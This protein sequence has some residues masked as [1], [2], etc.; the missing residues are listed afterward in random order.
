[1]GYGKAS[2]VY[3]GRGSRDHR[4]EDAEGQTSANANP[5]SRDISAL[6]ENERQ[7]HGLPAIAAM[8]INRD[9]IV[10]Q[11]VVGV[12]KLG[13]PE[14]AHIDDRWHTSHTEPIPARVAEQL[15]PIEGTAD[16]LTT[17]V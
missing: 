6:L 17:S 9:K 8:V 3:R 7:I 5:E 2:G 11:G 16:R 12:R 14:R 10:T 4:F 13:R 15:Q 1:M